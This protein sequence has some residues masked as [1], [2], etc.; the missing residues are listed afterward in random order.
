M[1]EL[2]DVRKKEKKLPSIPIFGQITRNTS[3]KIDIY[4]GRIRNGIFTELK[5]YKDGKQMGLN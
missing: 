3:K 2:I 4:G 1:R 5:Q